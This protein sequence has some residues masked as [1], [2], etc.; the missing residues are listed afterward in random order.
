MKEQS[1]RQWGG[2]V[3]TMIFVLVSAIAW[4]GEAGAVLTC[5][6]AR[7]MVQD[8]VDVLYVF[9]F[10]L[11]YVMPW[12]LGAG[13]WIKVKRTSAAGNIDRAIAVRCYQAIV[14]LMFWTYLALQYLQG[15]D[16]LVLRR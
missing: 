6:R 3:G 7:P 16:R 15:M 8:S 9:S 1:S 11:V 14:M 4:I 12:L 5:L 10:P 2:M 13:L